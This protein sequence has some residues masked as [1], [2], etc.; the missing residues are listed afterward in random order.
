MKIEIEN[1]FGCTIL[2]LV[3]AMSMTVNEDKLVEVATKHGYDLADKEDDNHYRIQQVNVD[4][5]EEDEKN[6]L[7]ALV[8]DINNFML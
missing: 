1:Y 5:T 4:N 7:I 2:L 6:D 3:F 8:N